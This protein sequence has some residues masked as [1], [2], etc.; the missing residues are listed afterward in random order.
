[1]SVLEQKDLCVIGWAEEFTETDGPVIF[2]PLLG[3][4]RGKMLSEQEMEYFDCDGCVEVEDSDFL[5]RSDAI[6]EGQKEGFTVVDINRCR[7][8]PLQDALVL[9]VPVFDKLE[10]EVLD[11]LGLGYCIIKVPIAHP[12]GSRQIIYADRRTCTLFLDR[13]A[14]YFYLLAVKNMAAGP[15]SVGSDDEDIFRRLLIA[16]PK[17]PQAYFLFYIHIDTHYNSIGS[18]LVCER[19]L[20][21][22]RHLIEREGGIVTSSR[23]LSEELRIAAHQLLNAELKGSENKF[24]SDDISIARYVAENLRDH[25]RFFLAASINYEQILC[26]VLGAISHV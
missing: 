14:C 25:D 12:G 4:N 22:A 21:V 11:A 20:R 1:M 9:Q 26:E 24:M 19:M 5:N 18:D 15:I 6:F 16:D 10:S 8:A 7:I 23:P 3:N 13:L 17:F 2:N